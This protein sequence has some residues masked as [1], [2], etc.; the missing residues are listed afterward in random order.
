MY[1]YAV[2]RFQVKSI[3][4]KFL[5]R[6]HTQNEGDSVHSTIEK[7]LKKAKK[8]GPIYV[9]DQYV[10]LIRSAKKKGYP[11]IVKEMSFRHFMDLKLLSDEMAFN[12]SKS[13]NGEQI[14]LSDIKMLRFEKGSDSYFYKTS[15]NDA[16]WQRVQIK[17]VNRRSSGV[18]DIKKIILKPAYNSKLP[19]SA[20]KKAD[21]LSLI[22]SNIIPRFYEP[23]FSSIL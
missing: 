9:P 19:I 22:Q 21:I 3:L 17:T 10:S 16:E 2:E 15:Y 18:R 13:V 7:S 20:N 23:A 12:Y 8:S 6:G 14:K 4:H 11:F 1:L 5:I